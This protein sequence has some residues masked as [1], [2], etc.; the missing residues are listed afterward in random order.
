MLLCFHFLCICKSCCSLTKI[1]VFGCCTPFCGSMET[2]VI[3]VIESERRQLHCNNETAKLWQCNHLWQPLAVVAS[4][5]HICHCTDHQDLEKKGGTLTL[6][7]L[8]C[9]LPF[10]AATKAAIFSSPPLFSHA[11]ACVL[12]PWLWLFVLAIWWLAAGLLFGGGRAIFRIINMFWT[13]VLQQ[14]MQPSPQRLRQ[15]ILSQA[16][17]FILFLL[18]F[19]CCWCCCVALVHPL[20]LGFNQM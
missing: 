2:F 11:A 16:W 15:K 17:S 6:L 3:Q 8:F 19:S 10:I 5:E 18:H 14:E 7:Q 20:P 9:I 4:T 1:N 13:F 12:Q